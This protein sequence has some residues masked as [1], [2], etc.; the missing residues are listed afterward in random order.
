MLLDIGLGKIFFKIRP[1]KCRQQ[2]QK[3]ASKITSNLK[4]C[5]K[6]STVKRQPT[7]WDKIFANHTS[8]LGLTSKIYMELKEL[9]IKKN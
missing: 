4:G 5:W 2:K 6:Q 9:K 1:E 3:Q 7:K 8:D